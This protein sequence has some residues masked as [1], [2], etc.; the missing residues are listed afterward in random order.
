MTHEADSNDAVPAMKRPLFYEVGL[1]N[2]ERV[3]ILGFCDR[4]SEGR[5]GYDIQCRP[6]RLGWGAYTFVTAPDC[7]EQ[8]E[9]YGDQDWLATG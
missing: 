7:V 6:V 8:F 9:K 4:A 5:I 3:Y 2:K 1:F